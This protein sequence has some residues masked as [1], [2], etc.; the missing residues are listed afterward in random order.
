MKVFEAI[1]ERYSVRGYQDRPVEDEKLKRIME[2]AGLAPSARNRQEWRYVVV[3]DEGRRQQLMAAANGREFVGRAPVIIAACSRDDHYMMG[4]KQ[5][6]TQIDVAISIEHIALQAVE[7][8]LGTCW[9]GA[10]DSD[11]ARRAIGAPD[12]VSV[13]LLMTLGYPDDPP[14]PKTRLPMDEVVMY[15]EWRD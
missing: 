5:P 11:A 4:C 7:E 3:R 1:Q 8:G 10:F 15:D 9:I 6:A 14:R 13:M 12:D 2:A